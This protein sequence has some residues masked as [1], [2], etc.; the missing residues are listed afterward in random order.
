MPHPKVQKSH[1]RNRGRVWCAVWFGGLAL[2]VLLTSCAPKPPHEF[3]EIAPGLGYTNSRLTGQPLF[4]QVVRL[5]RQRSDLEFHSTHANGTTLGLTRISEQIEALRPDLGT[6]LVAV[7]GDYYQY[8]GKPYPG[9]P[10]GVQIVDGELISA[11]SGGVALWFDASGQPRVTNVASAFCVT[12]PDG[13]KTK[14]GLNEARPPTNAVL[15]TPGLGAASTGTSNGLELV[16]E[17][18]GDSP[19]FPLHVGDV[20]TARVREVCPF[21]DTLITPDIM[22]LSVGGK[23]AAKLPA[24]ESGSVVTLSL[25]TVPD[26]T[27][28]RTA[29]GGGPI[30][31]SHGKKVKLPDAP[32]GTLGTNSTAPYEFSS[33]TER[34]PRTAVGW[35]RDYF[36]F[37]LVDGRQK[38]LSRGMTL[39][40]LSAYM[41]RLGCQDV[42]NLDGGGSATLWCKGEIRNS[43]SEGEE[44]VI[45]N[46]LVAVRKP[47]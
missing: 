9:D 36:Y 19:W 24:V 2:A 44:R 34:H 12:W 39:D 35:N 4:I 22:V 38:G 47:R 8:K 16:L 43:P 13:S 7:N 18:E 14:I 20:V 23:L 27:G 11:P 46:A 32:L 40:E 25:N 30:L 41:R 1:D 17:R 10:R 15:Y 45:A 3:A 28:V 33:M 26:L 42:M 21:G 5:D 31:A 29:I 37:V 6:P